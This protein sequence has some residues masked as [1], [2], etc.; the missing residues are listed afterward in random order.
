MVITATAAG[1]SDLILVPREHVGGLPQSVDIWQELSQDGGQGVGGN[2]GGSDGDGED[3][4]ATGAE[5]YDR[6]SHDSPPSFLA[7]C[8]Q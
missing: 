4:F 2:T 3:G 6:F 7:R 8:A 1:D 5:I